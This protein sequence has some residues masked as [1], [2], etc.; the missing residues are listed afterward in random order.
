M[1]QIKNKRQPIVDTVDESIYYNW[2]TTAGPSF[3]DGSAG[4]NY[5]ASL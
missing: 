4:Q 1:F 5:V 3:D 2:G